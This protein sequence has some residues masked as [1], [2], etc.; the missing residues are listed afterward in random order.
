MRNPFKPSAGSHPPIVVDR[1]HTLESFIEGLED[2][3]GAPGLLTILTGPRGI[4]KTVMLNEAESLA[5]EQGWLVFSDTATKGFLVRLAEKTSEYLQEFGDKPRGA[6]ISGAGFSGA[7]ITFD[8]PPERQHSWRIELE[9]L[10]NRLSRNSTGLIITL[11]E[12]HAAD[13]EQLME[14]AATVQHM[15]REGLDV[16]MVMAG[17]PGAVS[18][19]LNKGVSTFLR[20]ADRVNLHNVDKEKVREAFR[21]TFEASSV[22]LEPQHL[23]IMANATGGYPFL[24]QLVGYHVWRLAAKNGGQVDDKVLSVGIEAANR[25][26]GSTVLEASFTGLSDIDKTFLLKM[27]QDDG[28]SKVSEVASRMGQSVQYAGVYRRR[29]IDAGVIEAQGHGKVVFTM[30]LLREY[31]REHASL[32]VDL[33]NNAESALGQ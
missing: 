14:L 7:T 1:Q 6:R 31:L 22:A 20:R 26:L 11:D 13:R 30:P 25:K 16:G 24:V 3:S 23:D 27:A 15:I 17:L 10:L 18:D 8:L 9:Q 4:G 33:S 5:Q 21:T 19:L 2:G 28:P 12:V 29:L 32:L